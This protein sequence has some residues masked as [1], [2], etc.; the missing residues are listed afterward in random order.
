M[1]LDDVV[2]GAIIIVVGGLGLYAVCA[3]GWGFSKEIQPHIDD[4]FGSYPRKRK[5][6]NDS[7]RKPELG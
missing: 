7:P 3:I 1:S 5:P 2:F 6:E 4:F